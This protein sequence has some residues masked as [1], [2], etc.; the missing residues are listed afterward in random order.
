MMLEGAWFCACCSRQPS[1]MK[2]RW[3][4]SPPGRLSHHGL[5][6][7]ILVSRDHHSNRFSRKYTVGRGNLK[8]CLRKHRSLYGKWSQKTVSNQ[9][10]ILKIARALSLDVFLE[11]ISHNKK[12]FILAWGGGNNFLLGSLRRF[13]RGTRCLH[14]G[15]KGA[16]RNTRRKTGKQLWVPFWGTVCCRGTSKQCWWVSRCWL[17]RRK[18]VMRQRLLGYLLQSSEVVDIVLMTISEEDKD[19]W[20]YLGEQRSRKRQSPIDSSRIQARHDRAGW[21]GRGPAWWGVF[22]AQN[23]TFI[24]HC[25]IAWAQLPLFLRSK[26]EVLVPWDLYSSRHAPSHGQCGREDRAT[27]ATKSS[28]DDHQAVGIGLRIH[29]F[30][31]CIQWPNGNSIFKMWLI[32]VLPCIGRHRM[33]NGFCLRTTTASTVLP[34]GNLLKAPPYKEEPMKAL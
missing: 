24:C 18:R 1:S 30:L 17:K 20:L 5:N 10:G 23:L 14:H 15:V 25:W 31:K 34:A 12:T 28:D 33:N 4:S 3:I 11:Y 29:H 19:H 9:S 6:N 13:G 8:R 16:T 21:W 26:R 7:A 2:S 32:V 22:P 27:R